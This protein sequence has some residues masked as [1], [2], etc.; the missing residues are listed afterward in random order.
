MIKSNLPHDPNYGASLRIRQAMPSFL[1]LH[2]SVR[3]TRRLDGVIADKSAGC[4]LQLRHLQNGRASLNIA[5]YHRHQ[6]A[7][8]FLGLGEILA[9][10]IFF[11]T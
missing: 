6:D 3:K 9:H 2:R 4:P 11:Q 1:A 8:D 5:P 7:V 10:G